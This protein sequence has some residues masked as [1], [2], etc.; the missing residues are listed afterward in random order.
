MKQ[1]VA[2]A[3]VGV[4]MLGGMIIP[5][6][7]SVL[8]SPSHPNLTTS[9]WLGEWKFRRDSSCKVWYDAEGPPVGDGWTEAWGFS[10]LFTYVG[11]WRSLCDTPRVSPTQHILAVGIAP[12]RHEFP[13]FELQWNDVQWLISIKGNYKIPLR[14]LYHHTDYRGVEGDTLLRIEWGDPICNIEYSWTCV[15]S[16]RNSEPWHYRSRAEGPPS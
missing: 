13:K 11:H 3:F 4:F 5:V 16:K 6:K 9:Y 2:I 8:D 1:I 10:S 14:L 15:V 12:G 7:P